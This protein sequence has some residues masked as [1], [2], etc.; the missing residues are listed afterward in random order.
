MNHR[1]VAGA[2]FFRKDE[3]GYLNWLA[4]HPDGYVVNTYPENHSRYMVLH[5]A[6][7]RF[8][9]R[10]ARNAAPGAFAERQYAK[11]CASNWD[12]I[13]DWVLRHGRSPDRLGNCHCLGH[14]RLHHANH[15]V[16]TSSTDS[17][18]IPARPST[19]ID[20][21]DYGLCRASRD[22]RHAL[23]LYGRARV[24]SRM[25]RSSRYLNAKG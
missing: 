25:S 17:K 9:S 8:I 2:I 3:Q 18:D 16:G 23:F 1:S 15:S 13:C 12:D 4:E 6:T 14:Q 24:Q 5:R 22:L 10:Y 20:G 19:V 7:C 11:A 21:D